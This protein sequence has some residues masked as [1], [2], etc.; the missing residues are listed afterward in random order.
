MATF[1]LLTVLAS[2]TVTACACDAYASMSLD[3]GIADAR[4]GAPAATGA[5]IIVVGPAFN[6]SM[7][8]SPSEA[9]DTRRYRAWESEAGA[10]RYTIT[11]RKPGYQTWTRT[12]IPLR[13]SG[14]CD[15]VQTVALTA[16]LVPIT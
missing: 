8:F 2:L 7:T 14:R 11:V 5:S 1:G 15:H 9:G 16:A 6:D 4:T 12:G 3:I 13:E 10:G